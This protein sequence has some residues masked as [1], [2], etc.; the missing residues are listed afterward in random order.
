MSVISIVLTVVH[1]LSCILLVLIVLMQSGKAGN[2]AAAF[3]GGGVAAETLFG[4]RAGNVLTRIT[5]VLA[6]ILMATALGLA[7]VTPQAA[8]QSVLGTEGTAPPMESGPAPAQTPPPP[9]PATPGG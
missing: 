4:S 3:G 8:S 9:A 6:V 1:V 5:A 7:V 2:I